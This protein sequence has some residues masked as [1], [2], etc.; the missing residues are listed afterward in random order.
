MG[1]FFLG[2]TMFSHTSTVEHI[3]RSVGELVD[4][5]KKPGVNTRA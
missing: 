3:L 2:L 5:S 4:L 1:I